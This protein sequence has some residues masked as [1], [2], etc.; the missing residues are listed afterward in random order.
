MKVGRVAG[1]F[2]KPRSA[3]FEDINGLSL[4][5]YRG[6]IINDMDFTSDAREPKAKKLLKSIQSKCSYNESF[7][8]IFK[9]WNG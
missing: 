8:S 1:Q 9:R 6:D 7:K 3:D 5:S 2:A 4:P